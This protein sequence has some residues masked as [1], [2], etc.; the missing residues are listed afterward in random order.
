[1]YSAMFA[2]YLHRPV[3]HPSGSGLKGTAILVSILESISFNAD[4]PSLT[5]STY[6]FRV[7]FEYIGDSTSK[8]KYNIEHF[9]A[10][11]SWADSGHGKSLKMGRKCNLKWPYSIVTIKFDSLNPL[12]NLFRAI[13]LKMTLSKISKI[14]KISKVTKISKFSSASKL[15]THLDR[16]ETWLLIHEF[17]VCSWITVKVCT[18][19]RS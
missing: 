3:T 9:S 17:T 5:S 15:G 2:Q 7:S 11:Q 18:L 10:Y 13:R 4:R 16:S 1:M 8:L 6:A 14:S 19:V 12:L